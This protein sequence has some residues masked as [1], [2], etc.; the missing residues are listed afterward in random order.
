VNDAAADAA[1]A[2]APAPYSADPAPAGACPACKKLHP[3]DE[4]AAL[5]GLA[6]TP[7]RLKQLL[8]GLDAKGFATS[9]GAGKWSVR[10]IVCHLRDCE[11]MFG[12]RW[13]L[14]LSEAQPALQSFDQD[15]WA[16]ATRY[17]KQDGEEA[18]ALLERLR[19]NNLQMLKLAGPQGLQRVGVHQDYGPI[20]IGQMAKHLLAHDVNHSAQIETARGSWLAARKRKPSA[21]KRRTSPR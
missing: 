17:E 14:I 4:K 16:G 18:L 5:R 8:K 20:T 15:H 10:Q 12:V 13:R 7:Q 1:T 3:G 2:T 6:R 21:R 9:Y 19:A 11:L